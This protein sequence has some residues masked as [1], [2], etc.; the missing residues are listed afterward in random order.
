[1]FR[2]LTLIMVLTYSTYAKGKY[3]SSLRVSASAYSSSVKETNSH[4]FLGAW[5][6][7]LNPKVKSIAISRD[8]LRMGLKHG[9]RVKIKGYKGTFLVLDKMNKRWRRKIDIYMGRNRK[10]ALKFGKKRL[11]IYWNKPKRK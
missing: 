8:L 5:G 1:M 4:P 3:D 6:N 2:T 7:R 10:K 11:T 9:M